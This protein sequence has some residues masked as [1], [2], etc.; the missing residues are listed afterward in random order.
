M[1]CQKYYNTTILSEPYKAKPLSIN[2]YYLTNY[3]VHDLIL[4][5]I[6]ISYTTCVPYVLLLYALALTRS[7]C[8]LDPAVLP[9]IQP[10]LPLQLE[11]DF[12]NYS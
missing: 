2:C 3:L 7:D 5:L 6:N 10:L 8:R 11:L 4:Y 9:T 12:L 1:R